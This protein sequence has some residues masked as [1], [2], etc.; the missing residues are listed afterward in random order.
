MY[1]YKKR[2][3][4]LVF[5]MLLA[6]LKR[7]PG[8]LVWWLAWLAGECCG[9]SAAICSGEPQRAVGACWG[10][11]KAKTKHAGCLLPACSLFA[12]ADH[13]RTPVLAFMTSMLVQ[14]GHVNSV[15]GY[16]PDG[17]FRPSGSSSVL[18][19]LLPVAAGALV[20]GLAVHDSVR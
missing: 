5:T 20:Q 7:L 3:Q 19:R 10:W 4:L 14:H 15:A 2:K 1:F 9:I 12:D 6:V 17:P 8:W 11:L 16:G 18:Q 13:A